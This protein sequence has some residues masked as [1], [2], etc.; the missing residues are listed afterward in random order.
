MDSQ[1]Y[2]EELSKLLSSLSK[3]E[4]E[5]AVDFYSEFISDAGLTTRSEIET[6][7]GTPKQLARKIMADHSV[8]MDDENEEKVKPARINSKMIWLIVLVILS[9]PMTLGL[10]GGLLIALVAIIL[11]VIL[12]VVVIFA[13]L[14]VGMAVTLYVGISLLFQSLNTGLFYIGI[15]LMFLGLLLVL[16]PITYWI[17]RVI[18]QCIAD[19]ARYLYKKFRSKQDGGK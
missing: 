3:D 5:A 8:R 18:L 7:L 2:L 17:C 10:G 16:L 6:R 9:S 12:M 15:F 1:R 11:S 4:V 14:I 19:F 13:G